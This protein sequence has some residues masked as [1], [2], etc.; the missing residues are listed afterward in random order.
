M[1]YGK[2]HV[3]I[4]CQFGNN[5]Y[6]CTRNRENDTHR[7]RKFIENFDMMAHSSIG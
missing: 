5:F 4:F 7:K 1:F 6:L 3:G 2:F